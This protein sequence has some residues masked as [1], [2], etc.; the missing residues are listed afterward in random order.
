VNA[1]IGTILP[2]RRFVMDDDIWEYLG[3]TTYDDDE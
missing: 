3:Y 2:V 1:P